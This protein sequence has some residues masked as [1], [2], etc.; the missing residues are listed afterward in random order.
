MPAPKAEQG[1]GPVPG[2]ERSSTIDWTLHPA[3][4]LTALLR[5]KSDFE[6]TA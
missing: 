3:D 5:L 6:T 1:R 4:T 2:G